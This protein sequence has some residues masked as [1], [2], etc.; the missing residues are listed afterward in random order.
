MSRQRSRARRL[1]LQALYRWQMT[2]EDIGG[3]VNDFLADHRDEKFDQA[4]FRDLVHGAPARLD[5]IDDLLGEFVDR[6]VEKLDEVERALLRAATW[7]LLE[8]LET[9]YRVVINEAVE[10]AKAFGAEQ[11]HKYVNG[12]LD[13]VAH[14]VRP[15]E[16]A[17]R[18]G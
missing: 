4:L 15:V 7:E 12:V 16:T 17:A 5:E 8:R 13:K 18:R 11:S 3:I 1:A 6:P 9:P 14:K 2:G 10:L